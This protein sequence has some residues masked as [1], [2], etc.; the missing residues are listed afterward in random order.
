MFLTRAVFPTHGSPT[1]V[2]NL[3]LLFENILLISLNISF[4]R[5]T[6]PAT[7]YGKLLSTTYISWFTHLPSSKG[8]KHNSDLS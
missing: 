5:P 4:Y 1:T 6:K 3:E 7:F 2:I 8:P